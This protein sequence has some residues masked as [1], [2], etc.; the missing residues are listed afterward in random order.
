MVFYDYL[1]LLAHKSLSADMFWLIQY[2]IILYNQGLRDS[3]R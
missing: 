1:A 2:F 3:Q